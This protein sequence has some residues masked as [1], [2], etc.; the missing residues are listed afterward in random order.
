MNQ[1]QDT[2]QQHIQSLEEELCMMSQE[3]VSY[4]VNR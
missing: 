4:K 1:M 2:H 3:L